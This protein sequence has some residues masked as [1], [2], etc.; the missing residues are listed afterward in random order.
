MKSYLGTDS[1]A[2]GL[3]LP[4]LGVNA[5]ERN[6]VIEVAVNSAMQ[7]RKGKWNKDVF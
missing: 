3:E 5:E 6:L 7:L 2:V 1:P 4:H